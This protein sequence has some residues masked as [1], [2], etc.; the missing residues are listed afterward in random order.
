ML[1]E[2]SA[3]LLWSAFIIFTLVLVITLIILGVFYL[4]W[5]VT[6]KPATVNNI[7]EE[8][9]YSD[10]EAARENIVDATDKAVFDKIVEKKFKIKKV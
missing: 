7:P 8:D 6:T 5:K 1:L 9:T 2:L 4:V 10:I 3:V